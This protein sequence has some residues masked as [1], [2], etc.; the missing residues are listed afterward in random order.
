[1][2]FIVGKTDRLACTAMTHVAHQTLNLHLRLIQLGYSPYQ[3]IADWGIQKPELLANDER[4]RKQS[5]LLYWHL[6]NHHCF[7]HTCTTQSGLC[8]HLA[9][10]DPAER[11][12]S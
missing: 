7:F 4:M 3:K 5:L 8:G 2:K 11:N 10:D 1:M 6:L 9:Q 12:S